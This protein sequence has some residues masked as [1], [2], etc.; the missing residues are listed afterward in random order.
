M[1]ELIPVLSKK[2]IE[3]QIVGIARRISDDYQGCELV[4][5]GVLKGAFVFLSDLVRHLSIPVKIDFIRAASYGSN[6]SSSG[7]LRLSAD[8][9]I[10]V[11]GKD[12]LIVEDIAD[13]GL[14]LESLKKHIASLGAKTVKICA[15]ID[16]QERRQTSVAIDYVCCTVEKGFLVGYGLDY[17]ENYRELPEVY[18]LKL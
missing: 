5:I 15:L 8:I 3:E 11:M 16:K 14:T 4:L 2:T 18:H 7:D 17:A 9:E 12:V 1:P 6:M 10:D 13:T